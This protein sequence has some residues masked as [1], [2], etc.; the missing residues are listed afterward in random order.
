ML[1]DDDGI[2]ATQ[3]EQAFAHARRYVLT[4][5]FADGAGTRERNKVYALVVDK[6]LRQFIAAVVNQEKHVRQ[7]HVCEC[8]TDNL[9]YRDATQRCFW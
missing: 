3:F 6:L 2:V 8:G 1:V 9:L 5:L 4:D 7:S